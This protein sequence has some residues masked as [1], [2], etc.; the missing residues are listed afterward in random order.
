MSSED[1]SG[2]K[3]VSRPARKT[4]SLK[5]TVE[6]GTVRQNFSHGR[7]KAV[8]VEKKRRRAVGPG[9]Q[10]PEAAAPAPAPAAP[11]APAPAAK[12]RHPRR[13]PR[14]RPIRAPAWCCAR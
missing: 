9:G 12:P 10:E 2:D 6:S 14:P 11:A 1:N 5:R 7:T 13:S 8:V 3:T 4:L